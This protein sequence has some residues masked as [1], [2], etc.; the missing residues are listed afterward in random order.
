MKIKDKLNKI[1][2]LHTAFLGCIFNFFQLSAS[3]SNF[4][5]YPQES[6]LANYLSEMP[7]QHYSSYYVKDLAWFWVDSAKDCVKDTIKEGKIWEP[8]IIYQLTQ[9]I[10]PG[11]SVIDIGAHMGTIS[12]AM[13]NLVGSEGKV[14]SFEG[15]RQFFREL[16]HNIYSNDRKNIFPHLCWLGDHNEDITFYSY[17]PDEYS[18]VATSNDKKPWPLKIRTLDSFNFENIRLIKM[19]VE[20]TEDQVLS[21]ALKTIESSRPIIIIEIMGGFGWSS[22]PV[23]HERINKTLETLSKMNYFVTKILVDDYLAIPNERL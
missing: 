3:E 8:Y 12:M 6:W 15:E 2:L 10:K 14:Y 13:S 18:P 1:N 23:V 20:C 7:W 22:D 17:Y 9:Y 21:G 5:Y 16:W 19:D 4:L 11:D